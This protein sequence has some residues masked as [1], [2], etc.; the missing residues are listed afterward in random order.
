MPVALMVAAVVILLLSIPAG[1]SGGG[2]EP[3]E[4]PSEPPVAAAVAVKQLKAKAPRGVGVRVRCIG[5]LGPCKGKVVLTEAGSG[6]PLAKARFSLR[7][8]E[9]R[10]KRIQLPATQRRVLRREGRGHL[11]VLLRVGGSIV[12]HVRFPVVWKPGLA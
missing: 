8:G 12:Y 9:I 10:L 7:P 2:A 3:T 1:A 11:G 6:K 4:P 5:E